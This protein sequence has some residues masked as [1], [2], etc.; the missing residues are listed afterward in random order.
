MPLSNIS[1][2][3]FLSIHLST[4]RYFKILFYLKTSR[5]LKT[6]CYSLI[7]ETSWKENSLKKRP[8]LMLCIKH[9]HNAVCNICIMILS[10]WI[11]GIKYWYIFWQILNSKEPCLN[12]PMCPGVGMLLQWF[13]HRSANW[14]TWKFLSLAF[15][16]QVL[17]HQLNYFMYN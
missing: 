15:T 10:T 6:E 13:R 11:S 9:S 16:M 8:C 4:Y 3:R 12:K 17:P 1:S 2:R 14:K 5:L 7:K